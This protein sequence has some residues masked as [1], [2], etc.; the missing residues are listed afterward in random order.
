MS[1]VQLALNRSNIDAAV[2][3]YR[4]LFGAEVG[5]TFDV[6]TEAARLKDEGLALRHGDGATC[7]YA[8]QDKFW[9]TGADAREWEVYTVLAD[10]EQMAP[11]PSTCCPS[12]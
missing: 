3:F 4:R 5:S 11:A 2:E 12:A 7:C 6:V 10:A 9:I 8:K 1:R